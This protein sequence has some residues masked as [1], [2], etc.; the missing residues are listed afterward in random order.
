MTDQQVVLEK[1]GA[2]VFLSSDRAVRYAARLIRQLNKTSDSQPSTIFKAVDPASLQGPFAAI[3]VGLESFTASLEFQ[4]ASVIQVDWKPA[5]GG[6]TDL[7]ALLE[8]MKG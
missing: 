6:N 2:Q 1:A 8:K 5:A 7:A 4:E 3:N